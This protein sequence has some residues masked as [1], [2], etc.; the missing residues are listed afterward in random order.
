M[1][2]TAAVFS[3][4]A[5]VS[6]HA[7]SSKDVTMAVGETQTFYLPSS[8]TA[9]NLKSVTFY[10][11]GISYVQVTSYTKYSVTVKAVKAFSSPVIV[12]C[13]YRYFLGSGSFIY[14][15]S[16]YYDYCITVAGGSTNVKPT[17]IS[18]P[19]TIK[20]VYI[21]ESVQLTPTVLP[22]NAE[23]TLT[24]SINDKSV[25]TVSQS[26]ILVGKSAGEA[27]L[28]VMADNGVYDMLRVVVT[29]PKPAS[30]S[31]SPSS[32]IL[33][34]GQSRY[35]TAI[36]YPSNASRAVS[37][38][39]SNSSVVTVSSS[40]RVSAVKVGTA[41]ITA[42]TSNGK[43]ATCVVTCK[44]AIPNIVLSDKYGISELPAK[45]NVTYERTLHKGWNSMCVPFSVT[46]SMLKA[47][48]E[49]FKI[50]TVSKYEIIGSERVLSVEEVQ[51]VGAGE[52]CLIYV[53]Q[54]VACR[55]SLVEASLSLA[56]K[57][58]RELRGVY[59]RTTVGP[60]C[61]KLTDDGRSFG[62]TRTGEA[63]VAPFRAYVL[64]AEDQ[65]TKGSAIEYVKIK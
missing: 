64:L 47:F 53:P 61:Y 37:W 11:G 45:A 43:K 41:T 28:K 16:G 58:A 19:S 29:D 35:L 55:F 62:V 34:E 51:T 46:R 23:Y 5:V 14:E 10:S 42:T 36:V 22:A 21:G 60:D 18:F 57:G 31:V 9:K 54:D 20:V 59:E 38:S 6:T 15:A 4:V 32:V 2:V 63:I 3:C 12:R 48:C 8:V 65:Q 33:T 24:W 40:G 30:V 17:S 26:G 52:P 39:S 7:Q 50:A 56:P 1:F 44:E 13:D 27:D 25:A 49:D